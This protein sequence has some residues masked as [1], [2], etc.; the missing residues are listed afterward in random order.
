MGGKSP[1]KSA[2]ARAANAAGEQARMLNQEQTYANRPNQYNAWGSSEWTNEP[3]KDPVTGEMMLNWTQ[4]ETLAD[5]LQK[6]LDAQMGLQQGRSEMAHSRLSDVQNEMGSP[7]D[8]SRYGGPVA[9]DGDTDALR[10]QSEDASYG[11]ATSRLD[12]QYAQESQA[13][14]IKL[15]NQGLR[16]GDASYDAQMGS[17]GRSKN[18][19]YE[20]ARMGST[21]EGRSEAESAFS[22]RL[23]GNERSNALRSQ[24]IQED[25]YKRG[26]SLDEINAL[27]AG[28]GVAGSTPSSVDQ[29]T[30][31]N[32]S[33]GK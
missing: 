18:D 9:F 11:R 15:R 24:Q 8:F 22:Q 3:Y 21:L 29:V 33:A 26:H 19:A 28:Q 6:S 14:E 25:L 4:K 13:L 10:K 16:A 2:G 31:A 5:P 20:Q 17:F 12:P 7:M 1:S 30:T 32:P 27:L 23:Q